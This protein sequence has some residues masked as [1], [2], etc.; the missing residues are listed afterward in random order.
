MEDSYSHHVLYF[1][2]LNAA[3]RTPCVSGLTFASLWPVEKGA[4]IEVA[5]DLSAIFTHHAFFTSGWKHEYSEEK[6]YMLMRCF[7]A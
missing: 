5:T 3:V 6:E 4:S 7:E 2:L 1:V